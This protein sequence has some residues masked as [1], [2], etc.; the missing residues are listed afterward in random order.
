MTATP[1]EATPAAPAPEQLVV[2]PAAQVFT[3]Q[4]TTQAPPT[5]AAP[6]DNANPWD[7]PAAAKLEIERLRRENGSERV[8]AKASAADTARNELA[9]Q[10]G[11]AL[12]LVKDDEPADPKA[13][14]D[15]LTAAQKSAAD[16]A[17]DFAIF[18]A[19]TAAK[20]D[21]QALLDSLTFRKAVE[22]IDPS[23]TAALEAAINDAVSSNPRFKTVQAAG[24]SGADFTG[25]TGEGAITQAKFDAMTPSER[26]GLF[27]T[28]PT[29]Y[30]TL[31][32]R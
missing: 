3:P 26:N 16:T 12:G 29:L 30:R 24:A 2:A 20:A 31:S 13:L 32:G 28:N 17:R 22:G 8:S 27:T 25:G 9:Q 14:T 6:A 10:I 5:P 7:D 4:P 23:N 19:A 21:P 15:Q 11:K 18:K 1:A